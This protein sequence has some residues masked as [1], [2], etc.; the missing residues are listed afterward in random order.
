[1]TSLVIGGVF[2]ITDDDGATLSRGCCSSP[3][4]SSCHGQVLGWVVGH[5]SVKLDVGKVGNW[6]SSSLVDQPV[7]NS[8]EA[9]VSSMC[10]GKIG[11]LLRSGNEGSGE[12]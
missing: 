4:S 12:G 9:D 8:S 6:L 10:L 5:R 11:S 2:L 7:E 1:M 3:P